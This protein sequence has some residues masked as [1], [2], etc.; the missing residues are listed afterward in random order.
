MKASELKRKYIE[1]FKQYNHKEIP[2]A[3][4][5]PENDPTVLF[6]TAGMHPLVPFLAGQKHPAGKKL[7]NVQRCIRTGDI[8]E[9][10]NDYHLTFFEMLGNWSLGDYFKEEA[11][12]M[13]YEFLTSKK[14][15]NLSP[16]KLAIS[17][18][19]GDKDAP[20]DEE[21][22][23][24][25]IQLGIPKERIAYLPK[26]D[27]WWGPAGLTGPCGPD[28]EMFCWN[29]P[30]PVPKKFDSSDK[31]WVEIWNDV[32]MQYEKTKINAILVDA[33]H[34]LFDESRKLNKELLNLLQSYNTKL[35]VV[36]N[37]D[38]KDE[39][40]QPL[41]ELKKQNI[42]V[43]TINGKP[44]KTNPEYFKKLLAKYNLK[45]N[46]IIYFDHAKENVSAAKRINI[47]SGLFQNVQQIKT[48]IDE[49]IYTF[50]SLK[51]KNVDTGMGVER[52]V[53][54]LQQKNSVYETESFSPIINK[55]KGLAKIKN[56]RSIRIIA[57]HL[58]AS[59]FILAEGIQ[60]SN[61]EQGYVLRRL[62][63]TSI[64]HGRL[65]GIENDF[66]T[67]IAKEV[68]KIYPEYEILNKNKDFIFMQLKKEEEK[69]KKTLSLGLRQ[70]EKL[71]KNKKIT[72]KGAF[73]LF[74][75][76]GFPL[77]MTED[78]AKEHKIKLNKKEFEKEFKKHQELSRTATKG[79]FRS[80]LI[81]ESET[82]TKLHTAT[83][84]LH[85]ALR[86]IL[87]KHVQQ[88]GSNIT[89]ERLRFDFSHDKKL[90]QEEI[91]KIETLV[92][93]KIKESLPIASEEMTPEE[94]KKQGALGFFEHKYGDKVS[95]Y[96][97]KD[98][99]KEI[100]TG[101]HVKNTKEIGKFKI[102]KEEAVA[103]GIRRIK[104]IIKK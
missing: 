3:S 31:N 96:T 24:I 59:V 100:C 89:P 32:F 8:H 28:T 50:L 71:I 6:T 60:P 86:Q 99:S 40:N 97:I 34:C 76:Y 78:L 42:E 90:T 93:K 37:A 85:A 45:T 91:K 52:T 44:E 68:I 103:S 69:F 63:R 38:L 84:L 19:K 54:V 35:I 79:R 87:G 16:E 11:I 12:K 73:I 58:K 53:T 23:K 92:N 77:E 98:F 2:N 81:D 62:I 29:S 55:I 48:F 36:T 9:V 67:P 65:L 4:L 66:T 26:K 22:A 70:F 47:N 30:K 7:V 46:E 94:A 43:F 39:K 27:N 61:L 18:F 51:Q 74:S 75:T 5:I 80:G 13:S 14:W 95:V 82:T 17:V 72:G 49:N 10:G 25:W 88:K 64:R 15:L 101:P 102:I 57:D 83:H 21:S 20:R 104:A 56:E 1:F 41:S 33:I